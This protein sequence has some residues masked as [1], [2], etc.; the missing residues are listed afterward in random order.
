[1]IRN[2]IV[3]IVI[4][5]KKPV[6]GVVVRRTEIRP[7]FEIRQNPETKSTLRN[8]G[9]MAV[10]CGAGTTIIGSRTVAMTA[11]NS[12]VMPVVVTGT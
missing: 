6:T 11:T 3:A 10:V 9:L 5:R 2:E 1:M 8:L 7:L 12:S 4:S